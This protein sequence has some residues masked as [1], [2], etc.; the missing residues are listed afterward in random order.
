MAQIRLPKHSIDKPCN[1]GLAILVGLLLGII[2]SLL[3][4]GG[5]FL[6]IPA[7]LLPGI[8]NMPS[9]WVLPY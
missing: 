2:T 1:Y 7:L 4:V 9:A 8:S 3:G 5:G 6:M